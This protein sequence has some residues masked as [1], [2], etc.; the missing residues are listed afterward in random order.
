MKQ[1]EMVR[2]EEELRQSYQSDIEGLKNEYEMKIDEI[3]R[4]FEKTDKM[5]NELNNELMK[6]KKQSIGNSLGGW[7]TFT[8]VFEENPRKYHPSITLGTQ[9]QN[10]QPGSPAK[11]ID[12][13][14]TFM[15]K[16]LMHTI[17]ET[18]LATS[19]SV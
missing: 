10:T 13:I 16:K 11:Q 14:Q 15:M 8:V 9:S 2:L 18:T 12:I 5:K 6:M 3:R 17:Q 1:N 4:M 19:D 7:G